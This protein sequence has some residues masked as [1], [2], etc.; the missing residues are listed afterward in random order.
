MG[1]GGARGGISSV[2]MTIICCT[3]TIRKRRN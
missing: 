1:I 2:T 3:I